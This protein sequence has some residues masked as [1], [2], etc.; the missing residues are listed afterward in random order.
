VQSAMAER[1]V[2]AAADTSNNTG[3]H[4]QSRSGEN[5]ASQH[6]GQPAG[7]QANYGSSPGSGQAP[8][9][10]YSAQNLRDGRSGAHPSTQ[11][12]SAE[13]DSPTQDRGLFA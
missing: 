12:G 13:S 3:A 10:P 2:V 7:Q 6:S 8:Y 9:Q 5:S 11:G 4:S 1:A